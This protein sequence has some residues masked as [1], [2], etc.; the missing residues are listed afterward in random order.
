MTFRHGR[1]F[2][3]VSSTSCLSSKGEVLSYSILGDLLFS[4]SLC[5]RL[6][7]GSLLLEE[8]SIDLMILLQAIAQ[9][10]SYILFLWLQQLLLEVMNSGAIG[11]KIV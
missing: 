9:Y 5:G 11:C 3:I 4:L 1:T 6:L 2:A 8:A 10:A 7:H